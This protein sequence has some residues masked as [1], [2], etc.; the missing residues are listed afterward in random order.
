MISASA[1]GRDPRNQPTNIVA[2]ATFIVDWFL[3]VT[4]RPVRVA[5]PETQSCVGPSFKLN[6]EGWMAHDGKGTAWCNANEGVF[7][8]IIRRPADMVIFGV[9]KSRHVVWTLDYKDGNNRIEY[10]LEQKSLERRVL[11]TG[12]PTVTAKKAIGM[13]TSD[14]WNLEIEVT[15]NRIEVRS[16]GKVL[17]RFDRPHPDEPLGKFGFEGDVQLKNK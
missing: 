16:D 1:S 17:D 13:G 4:P 9:H 7:R 3:T 8:F 15:R 11:R 5:T 12:A 6:D 14:T 10:Q 2:G